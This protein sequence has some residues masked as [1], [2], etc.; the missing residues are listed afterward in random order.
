[1]CVNKSATIQL[2]F[3]CVELTGLSLM[4]RAGSVNISVLTEVWF[5][6]VLSTDGEVAFCKYTYLCVCVGHGRTFS[7]SYIRLYKTVI[8]KYKIHY[9]GSY[10]YFRNRRDD[11]GFWFE[12]S[13]VHGSGEQQQWWRH[14]LL[15]VQVQP[16][17]SDIFLYNKYI[18]T[19]L[20]CLKC[21]TWFNTDIKG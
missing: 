9:D 15:Q 5:V 19:Y 20:F 16:L 12:V 11:R 4:I 6:P 7:N 13:Q 21:N 18:I 2:L 17:S 10:L 1:M 8:L 14:V 3:S